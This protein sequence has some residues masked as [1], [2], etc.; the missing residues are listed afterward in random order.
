MFSAENSEEN[1]CP[2][3]FAI[4]DIEEEDKEESPLKLTK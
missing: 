1:D 4:E 3:D 2:F